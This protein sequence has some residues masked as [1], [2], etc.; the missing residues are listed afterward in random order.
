[1]HESV[2][3]LRGTYLAKS[4]GA[5]VLHEFIAMYGIPFT[6]PLVFSLGFKLLYLSGQTY[7]SQ[8]FYSIV[9]ET[10][11]FPVQIV[12]AAIL[13]WLLGRSLSHR[14]ILWVWVLPSAILCYA[15]FT[16]AIVDFGPSSVL[17][18]RF[19]TQARISHFFGWGCRPEAH[20]LDQ[21]LVTMPFYTSLVYSAGAFVA[22]KMA[23]LVPISNRKL[24]AA[25]MLAGLIIILA[26][27]V[28]LII[29]TKQSGWQRAYWLILATPVGLGAYL[30]YVGSTIRR[31]LTT[32]RPKPS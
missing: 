7:P 2:K 6:A 20:C 27:V 23:P 8:T 12:F 25:T 17:A 9:S 30:L 11:Y 14:S 18:R 5:F 13:G 28:D 16:G 1:M 26:I 15:F 31:Q 19:S 3:R 21:L 32:F 10:P 22:R 4:A 29:S 24:Y